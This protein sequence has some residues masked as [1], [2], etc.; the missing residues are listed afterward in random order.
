MKKLALLTALAVGSLIAPANAAV[1]TLTFEGIGNV[2]PVGNFYAGQGIVFSPD[3]L[4]IV[5]LDA[6]GTGN[7]ANEPSG[8]TVMFFL[9]SNNAILNFAAGF[10]TGFSFFYSSAQAASVNVY[11]GLNGMGNLLGS[12]SLTGQFNQ[13]CAGDP[14]GQ[15][16][17]WTAVGVGFAGIARSIDFGGTANQVAFD[18]ITFG[19]IDPGGGVPEPAAWAMMIA[20][21]GLVGGAMRRRNT[22]VRVTYA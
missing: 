4:A 3:T 14:N 21:F 1:I 11:D 10:D 6:G 17:N 20:G 16:C 12:L 2:N 7:I 5:D 15:F 13:G 22:S 19:S 9:N 8:Q 18:N